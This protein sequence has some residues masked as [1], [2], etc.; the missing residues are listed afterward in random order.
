[1]SRKKP[2]KSHMQSAAAAR[3]R[4]DAAQLADQKDRERRRMSP[5]ARNL[6]CIALVVLAVS[7]LLYQLDTITYQA[8]TAVSVAVLI[9]VV[10]ALAVQLR[11]A[12]TLG[13]DNPLK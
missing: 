3:S 7:E 9:L 4:R 5:T 6:L 10:A 11:H 2:K 13:R 12:G 1:M 8:A